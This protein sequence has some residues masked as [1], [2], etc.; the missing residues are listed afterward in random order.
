MPYD[1]PPLLVVGIFVE[2]VAWG[3]N[4]GEAPRYRT[5]D[6]SWIETNH[7]DDLEWGSGADGNGFGAQKFVNVVGLFRGSSEPTTIPFTKQG[8]RVGQTI[9]TMERIRAATGKPAQVYT[10]SVAK[11]T[12]DFGSWFVYSKARPGGPPS[13]E[14]AEAALPW[15]QVM[16]DANAAT[17][18]VASVESDLPGHASHP[19]ANDSQN[20]SVCVN[21]YLPF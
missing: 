17:Q 18:C 11:R 19:S 21:E 15:V 12:N 9:A 1:L 5:R 13:A 2:N 10:V 8:I 6:R 3:K 16:A 4:R 7:P 20:E 14:L